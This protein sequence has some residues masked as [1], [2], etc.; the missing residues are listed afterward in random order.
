MFLFIL[1]CKQRFLD[2]VRDCN[3][4]ICLELQRKLADKVIFYQ[5]II[6]GDLHSHNL[7]LFFITSLL[8]FTD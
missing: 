4:G 2:F 8:L 7:V 5:H 6:F 3:C 1:V